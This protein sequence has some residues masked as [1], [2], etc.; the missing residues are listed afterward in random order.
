[1]QYMHVWTLILWNW[2]HSRLDLSSWNWSYGWLWTTVC[3]DL[4]QDKKGSY[5]LSHFSSP[6]IRGTFKI[7]TTTDGWS[8][9]RKVL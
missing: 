2:V 8:I 6:T 3:W 1:M 5:P 4:L 7:V 9:I